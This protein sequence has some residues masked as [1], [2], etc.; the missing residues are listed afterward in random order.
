MN[1]IFVF[2]LESP[3]HHPKEF[4]LEMEMLANTKVTLLAAREKERHTKS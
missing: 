1:T 4:E 2:M 3:V